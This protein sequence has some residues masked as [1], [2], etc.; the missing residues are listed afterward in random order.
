MKLGYIGL[1][2]MGYNMAELLLEKGHRIVAYNRSAEPVKKIAERGA[3]P[4]DSIR[5]LAAALEPP[6]L[7][8]IMVPY[9]AVDNVLHELEPLLAKGDTIIDGGNSPYKESMRRAKELEGKGI[10]FLDAG[11]SGGPGGARSGACIMV[12]GR[13]SVFRKYERLFKDASVEGGYA[14]FGAAGAGHFVKM[15]H[16][17]IEYGMMQALAEGFAVMKA[18]P[19]NLDLVK[20]AD[21]YNHRSVIESRLVGW[22]KNAYEQHGRDLSG[23]SGSAA[24]SG[25]GMWTVEAARE[26]GVPAPVIERALEFRIQSQKNPSYTGKIISA[27][28]NQFGGHEAGEK[29]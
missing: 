12:G 11:V 5:S 25:E 13:E 22:L 26:L 28:R 14:Y 16:N 27:L 15:V 10:D 9:Q 19:F 1:G 6:R 21:L 8:W 23:I 7:I 4:A 29:A 24:Q 2:K 20:I 3:Q 18:S 17:G